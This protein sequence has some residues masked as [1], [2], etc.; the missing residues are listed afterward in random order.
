MTTPTA[1]FA[2]AAAGAR[3]RT[4][5]ARLSRQLRQQTDGTLTLSQW[6]AL[7]SVETAGPMRIGDI[8]DREHV[9]PP[10]A[11]RLVASLEAAGL[12]RREVDDDDRRSALVS[13][14]AAGEQALVDARRKRTQALAQ[15]LSRWS[16]HDLARLAEALPLLERLAAESE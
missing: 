12:V 4:V 11:T 3:L 7:V 14:T 9:S 10:T 15:R 5:I 2:H 1:T 16:P 13:L 8:A 6:S